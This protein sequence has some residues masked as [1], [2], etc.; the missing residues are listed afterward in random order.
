M[1]EIRARDKL[2]EVPEGP[3]KV[4]M[5]LLNTMYDVKPAGEPGGMPET[6][7]VYEVRHRQAGWQGSRRQ[8]AA[9]YTSSVY[10]QGHT[11]CLSRYRPVP[12]SCCGNDTST[13]LGIE[14]STSL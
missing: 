6:V 5:T 9:M 11:C 1:H 14:V 3:A 4:R 12:G 8:A 2:E 13:L 10:G 7:L